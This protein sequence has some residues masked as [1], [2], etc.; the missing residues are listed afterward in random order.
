[1]PPAILEIMV[2]FFF[3]TGLEGVVDTLDA[4]ILHVDEE[5]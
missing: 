2:F 3:F 5:T 1:M 4:V